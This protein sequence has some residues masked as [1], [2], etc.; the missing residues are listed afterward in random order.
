VL[1]TIEKDEDIWVLVFWPSSPWAIV[2]NKDGVVGFALA[3]QLFEKRVAPRG[4]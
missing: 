4:G 3:E 1:G 2:A